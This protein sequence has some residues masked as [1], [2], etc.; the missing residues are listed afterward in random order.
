MRLVIQRVLQAKVKVKDTKEI[1]GEIGKG[2]FVLVGICKDDTQKNAHEFAKKLVHLRVLA[3]NEGKM[4]RSLLDTNHGLL[5]VSQFTLYA[6]TKSG[7]RPSFLMA[8]RPDTARPIYEA[9]IQALKEYGLHV[10]TGRFGEY[11]EIETFL[12][13]PVTIILE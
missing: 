5:V 7:N 6:D 13:G 2:L 10:Q 1:A 9:F 12:D 4:N 8:A 3:D 11:M